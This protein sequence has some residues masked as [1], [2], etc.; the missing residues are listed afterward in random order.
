MQAERFKALAQKL[1]TK[2]RR[3][4]REGPSSGAISPGPLPD[5]DAT[6][7][8]GPGARFSFMAWIELLYKFKVITLI[9]YSM[10]QDP[11]LPFETSESQERP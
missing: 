3:R 8:S 7:G 11:D 2:F 6:A 5:S 4:S 9:L 10:I 1:D